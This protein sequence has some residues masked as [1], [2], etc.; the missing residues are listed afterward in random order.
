MEKVVLD[1]NILLTD[2]NVI[3]DYDEVIIPSAVLEE[4]DKLKTDVEIGFNA[5]EAIRKLDKATN[6][7]YLVKDIYDNVPIGWEINKRD[8]Q[9]VL[10]AR[11]TGSKLISNDVAVR[12][13]AKAL[14]IEVDKY[15]PLYEDYKG[16]QEIVMSDYELSVFY[17]CKTNKWNLNVNEYLI[18]KNED[19]KIIDKYKWTKQGFQEVK[20]TTLKSPRFGEIKPKDEYQQCA[21]DSLVNDS[22]TIL[23]GHAG[24]AKSLLSMAY[25]FWAIEHGKYDKLIIMTNP[26]SARG[27][28]QLGYYTGSR[29]EKMMQTSIGTML[30]SKFKDSSAVKTLV[31]LEQLEIIPIGDCRGMEIGK[32]EILYITEAQ[33]LDADLAKLIIQRVADGAKLILEGDIDAQVDSKLFSGHYSGI[34]KAIE[35]FKGEEIFSCVDLPLIY[36]SKMAAIADKM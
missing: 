22:F 34:R 32:N 2:A 36:R 13:K 6:V 21:I 9:I 10:C 15:Q 16:V 5:R 30:N 33:N 24:T 20:Y 7:T 1:T 3:D 25:A 4:L 31:G 26:I 23:T 19:G 18:I 17:Q 8:N 35:V 12:E 14:G 11:D 28:A 27:A 29:F